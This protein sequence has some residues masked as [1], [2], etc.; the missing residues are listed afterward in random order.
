MSVD[1]VV[2]ELEF[3]EFTR[4]AP[5]S[6]MDVAIEVTAAVT[7]V[8]DERIRPGTR[9]GILAGSRGIAGIAETVGAVVRALQDRGAHPV[10]IPAMGSHGGATADGQREVLHELGIDETELGVPLD[11]SMDADQ[12]GTL[13]N[14][15]PVHL[16]T[17]AQRCE[18]I[19]PVNR[20]KPH[21]D[22]R[23]RIESG[24]V[25]MLSIGIGKEL[26]ASSLHRAGFGAFGDILPAVA[27]IVLSKLT[28]PF[29]VALIED[30]WHRPYRVEAVP[31]ERIVERDAQLLEEAREHL[32]TLPFSEIDVLLLRE[33]GKNISGAGMDPNVTG[34]FAGASFPT[35]TQVLR[36]SVL[37]LTEESGGNAIGIGVADFV[38]ERL[39]DKIHWPSTYANAFAAKSP[40]SAKLPFV[41]PTDAEV[42]ERSIASLTRTGGDPLR[43]VAATNT[44][45]VNHIAV[46]E[47]LAKAALAAGYEPAG[48]TRRA[49]FDEN[50]ALQRIGDLQFFGGQAA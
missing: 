47:P 35:Q 4:S 24:L 14:G 19:I 13:A 43:M 20:V 39:R 21:S 27:N 50:G 49:E 46:T 17:S 16:A 42:I 37:D 29:G 5:P 38:P 12:V 23:A 9:V 30:A 3:T 11:A 31:G 32:G 48:G 15:L 25:K 7:P 45:A 44:L 22:F 8:V 33:I 41:V 6:T 18:A 34:R 26:G 1:P 10:I 40:A 2:S 36:L 28:V